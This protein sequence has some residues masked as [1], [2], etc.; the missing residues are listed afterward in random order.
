[1]WHWKSL[2]GRT[3]L[4]AAVLGTT[5]LGAASV[6]AQSLQ[7]YCSLPSLPITD[8]QTTTDQIVI[9]VPTGA[10][11]DLDVDLDISHTYVGDLDIALDHTGPGTTRT[12]ID[13]PGVPPGFGCQFDDILATVDDEAGVAA[14]TMCNSGPAISGSVIGGDPPDNTLLAAFDGSDGMGTWTLTVTDNAAVDYGTLNGWCLNLTVGGNQPPDCRSPAPSVTSLWPPNHKFEDIDIVGVT[15][16]DGD[17]VV[18]TI[19]AILQDEVVDDGG[20][21]SSAPDGVGVGNSFASLRAERAGDGNGRVYHVS[22]TADDG[23]GGSCQGEVRV[24][25]PKSRGKEGSPVDDGALHDSTV[26]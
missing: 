14:E 9:G 8:I 22:F 17:P 4:G 21:G 6:H 16:P 15:D 18:I 26:F 10:I 20:D 13:R 11:L 24:G 5:L 12:L 2:F 1:M 7:Q 19:D 25:V 23:Q 3:L